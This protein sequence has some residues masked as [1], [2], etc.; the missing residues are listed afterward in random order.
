M[1]FL[2]KDGEAFRVPLPAASVNGFCQRRL[3]VH[4]ML[5]F[6]FQSAGST[7]RAHSCSG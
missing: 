7:Y 5:A 4:N 3:L 1:T 6:N 2:G